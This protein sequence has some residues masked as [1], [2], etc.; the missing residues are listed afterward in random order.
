MQFD[1]SQSSKCP[2]TVTNAGEKGKRKL[3]GNNESITTMLR[4]EIRVVEREEENDETNETS[5]REKREARSESPSRL[6][7]TWFRGPPLFRA[8]LQR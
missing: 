6:S 8:T 7:S 5:S 4:E 1:Q 2:S 3:P